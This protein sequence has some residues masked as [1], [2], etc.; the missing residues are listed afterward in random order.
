M[1]TALQNVTEQIDELLAECEPDG[2]DLNEIHEFIANFVGSDEVLRPTHE[3]LIAA[4]LT[5]DPPDGGGWLYMHV[6][7]P[8]TRSSVIELAEQLDAVAHETRCLFE[9]LDVTLL[10][11]DRRGHCIILGVCDGEA[12][13]NA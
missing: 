7:R 5:G 11:G 10:S 2:E 4:G 13:Q 1:K 3:R 6:W 8:L 9:L 12:I